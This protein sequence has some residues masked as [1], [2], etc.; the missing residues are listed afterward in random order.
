[1]EQAMKL[2]PRQDC[3]LVV[4]D[5]QEKL[6]P[7][8]AE[9]ERVL[10]NALKLVKFAK[11]VGLPTIVTEQDKLGPTVEPLATELAGAPKFAKITF[12]CFGQED[13]KKYLADLGRKNLI[14]AGIEAHICVM[15]TA[16]SACESYQVQVLADAISSRTP[17]NHQL[18]LDRIRQAGMVITSTEMFIYEVLQKAGTT[19]FKES[20]KLVK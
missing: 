1:M 14:L 9:K 16:L 8:M 19:E 6:L 10:D 12:D 5:I 3:A 18:A 15:Q 4:I 20:L 7:V 13:F 11:I 17:L 2:L